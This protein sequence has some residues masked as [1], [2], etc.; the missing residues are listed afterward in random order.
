M[1]DHPDNPPVP[2]QRIRPEF[3]LEHGSTRALSVAF[4][5]ANADEGTVWLFNPAANSLVACYNSGPDAERIVGFGQPV[6]RGLISMVFETEQ[7][8]CE[9]DVQM[10]PAQDKS[11]DQK[12]GKPTRAL[13]ALPFYVQGETCG[14]ISC[15][16]LSS[17]DG[18]TGRDLDL[19]ARAVD[20]FQ[21]AIENSLAETS[22]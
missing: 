12:L 2:P 13:I 6:G 5:A 19:V 14:V 18:F 21:Q 7:A 17:G 3:L 8:F 15:V 4:A 22:G 10:N 1:R 16:R 9:N 20:S 11:L